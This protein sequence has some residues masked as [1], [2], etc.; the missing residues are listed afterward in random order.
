MRFRYGVEFDLRYAA[1]KSLTLLGNYTFQQVDSLTSFAEAG[2]ISPP[3]HK[4]MIG[5]RYSPADSVH[6]SSHLYFVD[7]T[8]APNGA[9]PVAPQSI[10]SYLRL[11]LRAEYELP[12][13]KGSFAIGVSN[14]LDHGH[15]EGGA[16]SQDN[17]EVPRMVF[18]EFRLQIK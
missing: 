9:F 11:D 16:S 4:F 1:T 8:E 13:D 5:A 6:L 7:S 10:D 2:S 15:A 18:A 3:K 12:D 14:L 17:A